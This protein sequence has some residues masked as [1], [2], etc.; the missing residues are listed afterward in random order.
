MLAKLTLTADEAIR[1]ALCPPAAG[2]EYG[3][4]FHLGST[5]NFGDNSPL[6]HRNMSVPDAFELPSVRW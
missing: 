1:K 3:E 5:K 6:P 4:S 2:Q